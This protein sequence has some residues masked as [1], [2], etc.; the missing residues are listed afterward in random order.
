MATTSIRTAVKS[1]IVTNLSTALAGEAVV[2]QAWPGKRLER[3]HVWVDRCTGTVEF[4]LAMSGRKA[5]NDN[6]TVRVAFQS[7]RPGDSIADCDERVE[8]FYA[9]LEDLISGDVS[10]G[11]LDGLVHAVLETV[12]GPVGE[13]T[14]EGA[15]SFMF[16]DVA[17]KARLY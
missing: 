10:L 2:S 14:D 13:L 11:N 3:D 5:R 12:E 6:F 8:E 16:A 4:P 7:A 15:V 9:E 17:C 1:Y